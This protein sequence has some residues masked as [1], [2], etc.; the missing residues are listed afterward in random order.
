MMIE[1]FLLDERYPD[2]ELSAYLSE[3]SETRRAIVIMPGGGYARVSS[4]EGEPIAK[5]YLSKGFNCFVLRYS[6]GA[7]AVDSVPLIEAALAI[8]HVRENSD[9]YC[10]DPDRIFVCG[11]SAGGHLA[12]SSGILWNDPI[13]RA[14]LGN[15]P[16]GINKPTG[17]ILS[18]P[19]ITA[20]E[21]AH[22]GSIYNLCGTDDPTEE[23]MNRCSLERHV[24]GTTPPTFIWH[25]FAD[26]VVPVENSLM[27]AEKL[28]KHKVPFEL[29]VFPDG[30]HGLALANEISCPS[31]IAPTV[32]HA[33]IWTELSVRWINTFF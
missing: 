33:A 27:L 30:E 29:H 6:V 2:C 25:T 19:V 1:S 23:Q 17:M 4:R 24:D 5:Y 10:V 9:R 13:V 32:S 7:R 3:D 18:Y 26:D 12:A 11:F 16:E 8:K 22:K 14:A 31:P 15:A 21:L 28:S 20:G